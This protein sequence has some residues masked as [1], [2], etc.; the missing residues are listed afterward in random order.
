MTSDHIFLASWEGVTDGRPCYFDL[1]C[2]SHVTQNLDRRECKYK[3][4]Y[5]NIF[6]LNLLRNDQRNRFLAKL[7][8]RSNHWF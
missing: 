6:D 8:K 2:E 1:M 5:N 3:L 7:T 4:T